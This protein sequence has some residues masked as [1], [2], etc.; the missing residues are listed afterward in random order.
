MDKSLPWLKG[1]AAPEARPLALCPLGR[2]SLVFMQD[3]FRHAYYADRQFAWEDWL[4]PDT[5]LISLL[6]TDHKEHVVGALV[7]QVEE[8]PSTLAPEWPDRIHC[9]GLAVAE[10]PQAGS[11]VRTLLQGGYEYLCLQ[12]ISGQMWLTTNL[13]WLRK[14]AESAGFEEVDSIRYLHRSVCRSTQLACEIVVRAAEDSEVELVAAGDAEAFAAPWHM[15]PKELRK[16]ASQGTLQV[17]AVGSQVRGY[18]LITLPAELPPHV[19]PLGFIVRLAVWPEFQR[20][21]LGTCLLK[22]AMNWLADHDIRQVRLNVLVSD[23]RARSFYA[24]HG[25]RIIRRPHFVF[26]QKLRSAPS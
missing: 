12:G 23:N 10:V 19:S 22:A 26:S 9:R 4:S 5:E 3:L 16:W 7:L 25:F 24:H 15:G 8:R 6:A 17:L 18:S 13:T 2:Q 1:V 20:Q 11:M 14:G 21:G